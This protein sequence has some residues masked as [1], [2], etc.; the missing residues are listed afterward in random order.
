MPQPFADLQPSEPSFHALSA[1]DTPDEVLSSS[2]SPNHIPTVSY[3][4]RPARQLWRPD[5]PPPTSVTPEAGLPELDLAAGAPGISDIWVPDPDP[6]A[7]RRYCE[8]HGC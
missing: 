2:S 6:R 5:Q 1:G 3:G 4:R 7:A 8:P